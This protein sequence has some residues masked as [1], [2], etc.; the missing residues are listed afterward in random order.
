MANIVTEL[1]DQR[2]L[3]RKVF[4]T[5]E[6]DVFIAHFGDLHYEKADG[7][8]D[9]LS[10]L[11]QQTAGGF[12]AETSGV[13]FGIENGAM[14]T[15][16]KGRSLSMK[17]V[18]IAMVD[19]SAPASRFRKMA[20]ADYSS[21]SRSGNSVTVTDIFPGVDLSVFI[22]QSQMVKTFTV[23]TKPVLPDPVSLGWNPATTYLVIVWSRSLPAQATVVDSVTG[24]VVKNGYIGNSDLLVKA[25]DG[26][27]IVTFKAGTARSA[28]RRTFPVSYVIAQNVPF[29]EAVA[30]S[31]IAV[32][33]YPFV[34]DP[35]TSIGV[36]STGNDGSVALDSSYGYQ[37]TTTGTVNR[38]GSGGDGK[39][40]TWV[41]RA[42][43]RM[44]LASLAGAT[45]SAC[46]INV[47]MQ[48]S[49]AGSGT[50]IT[51]YKTASDWY[52]LSGGA[53]TLGVT[54]LGT[55]TGVG[56]T[57][58]AWK[59]IALNVAYVVPGAVLPLEFRLSDETETS[60]DVYVDLNDYTAGS[61]NSP[62]L[63]ITYTTGGGGATTTYQSAQASSKIRATSTA[64]AQSRSDIKAQ[65]WCF[66]QAR[67]GIKGT[68]I[69][70]YAQVNA[71]V[72]SGPVTTPQ[73]AQAGAGIKATSCGI[74][75]A[76]ADILDWGQTVYAQALA[77]IKTSGNSVFAQ[78]MADIGGTARAWAQ[79]SASIRATTLQMAQSNAQ[80]LLSGRQ[81]GAQAQADIR[82]KST[83]SANTQADVKAISHGRA[84][85]QA[86]IRSTSFAVAQTR[87][88][89]LASSAGYAQALAD[90]RVI[91]LAY[92]QSAASVFR[93]TSNPLVYA[94]AQADIVQ[95]S[96][97][98]AQAQSDIRTTTQAAASAQ[99]WIQLTG[100][101]Y[102][103]TGA[104][105]RATSGAHAQAQSGIRQISPRYGQV[106]S[107]IKATSRGYAQSQAD[108]RSTP[109]AVAQAGAGILAPS[110]G[111]AQTQASIRASGQAYSLA[112]A[113]I[114]G[115]YLQ[116][117]QARACIRTSYTASGQASA[118]VLTADVRSAQAQA[119]VSSIY[120]AHAQSAAGIILSGLSAV[121]QAGGSV[122]TTC[123]AVAQSAASI[124]SGYTKSGNAQALVTA[125]VI[126]VAQAS[127]AIRSVYAQNAQSQSAIRAH[128]RAYAA[129]RADILNTYHARA[130]VGALIMHPAGYALASALI[131]NAHFIDH[132]VISDIAPIDLVLNARGPSV[133]LST[134]VLGLEVSDRGSLELELSDR[135][136]IT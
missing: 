26:S 97:V 98:Y 24:A 17:P 116:Y 106:Q 124:R 36:G 109:C 123:A 1:L 41:E 91:A 132:I 100:L 120:Q 67:A 12:V 125:A 104:S 70:A 55:S 61:G 42:Y 73:S 133:S 87:A 129:V 32:T 102:A 35:T 25:P 118:D 135:N 58:P 90:V 54:A 51:A 63:S 117:A 136:P 33:R 71:Q 57:F 46:T 18:S 131:V 128:E 10:N 62:Y 44:D 85:S 80:I 31:T 92:G 114:F 115:V 105:V 69:T 49:T 48:S 20:D 60:A 53:Y 110:T 28:M 21:V 84:Q 86:D 2:L 50:T 52:P 107:D 16:Y 88:D 94:Q 113:M 78:S 30:Y 99:A 45:I 89:V 127:A 47:S 14:T 7:S 83:A 108:I 13:R 112:S 37:M 3:N 6:P 119:L 5:D 34:I 68:G 81:A 65:I 59:A 101:A 130:Y 122:R 11:V 15:T 95:S 76:Q 43:A 96:Q 64:A 22:T 121:A 29:G 72:S 66:A 40:R 38:I 56:S 27:T 82:A 8:L 19:A 111:H 39:G 93:S 126:S 4:S 103:L 75:Q 9:D 134:R 79:A 74:A 77:D 23:K